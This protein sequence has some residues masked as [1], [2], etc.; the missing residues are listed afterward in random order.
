VRTGPVDSR[1][2]SC[3]DRRTVDRVRV[4]VEGSGANW[5]CKHAVDT[6]TPIVRMI[7]TYEAQT[8][9][10]MT[11][12]PLLFCS[13]PVDRDQPGFHSMAAWRE[14]VGTVTGKFGCNKRSKQRRARAPPDKLHPKRK[15]VP[16][17]SEHAPS[18]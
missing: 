17:Q 7:A 12:G 13:M 18:R 11:G 9:I 15:L 1:L 2:L 6:G 16:P 14:G 4:R 10:A 5:R 3:S 8:D